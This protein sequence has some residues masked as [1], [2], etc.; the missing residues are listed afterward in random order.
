MRV[1]AIVGMV[2]VTLVLMGC[3]GGTNPSDTPP[4]ERKPHRPREIRQGFFV[5]SVNCWRG[6]GTSQDANGYV[7]SAAGLGAASNFLRTTFGGP[8]VVG[9]QEINVDVPRDFIWPPSGGGPVQVLDDSVL[10]NQPERI[11]QGI[12]AD[13]NSYFGFTRGNQ[14]GRGGNALLTNIA[15]AKAGEELFAFDPDF[16]QWWG[17]IH[18]RGMTR[19]K[20][21]FGQ[22]R[23]LWVVTTHIGGE[24]NR[25]EVAMR[26]LF[27][28]LGHVKR[29]RHD[30][31]VI[32]MGDFN[33]RDNFD[34]HAAS[35]ASLN[36]LMVE[37]VS[38]FRKV[39]E[40]N[41]VHIY[42]YDPLGKLE[43]IDSGSMPATYGDIQFSD[44]HVV[45]GRF[46]WR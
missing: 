9:L 17:G 11:A 36:K 6:S 23:R 14:L 42:L 39:V 5:A 35:Y 32:V 31:P 41:R 21:D 28:L 25:G 45:W 44:H 40:H 43:E 38:G 22:G 30:Y 24:E 29:Y 18:N 8:G 16:P 15:Y 12:S 4:F 2:L 33:I 34:D 20:L 26:Q 10:W 46:V 13:W 37:D 7:G 1:S 27:E 19:A 3:Q